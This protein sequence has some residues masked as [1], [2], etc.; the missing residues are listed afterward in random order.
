MKEK[1]L[2]QKMMINYLRH[3]SNDLRMNEFGKQMHSKESGK[4]KKKVESVTKKIEFLILIIICFWV[5]F[6]IF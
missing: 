1:H 5:Y 2:L 3:F 6:V 4:I